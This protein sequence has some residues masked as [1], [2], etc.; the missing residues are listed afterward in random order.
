MG[1][2]FGSPPSDAGGLGR[3][4]HFEV[5]KNLTITSWNAECEDVFGRTANDVVG[6]SLHSA[7]PLDNRDEVPSRLADPPPP[8]P[9]P[10]PPLPQSLERRAV[11]GGNCMVPA[12]RPLATEGSRC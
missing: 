8:P 4:L 1:N 10:P 12:Y 3:V 5:D 9:P 6:G 11:D 7:V 2:S